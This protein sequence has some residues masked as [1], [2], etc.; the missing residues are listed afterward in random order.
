MKAI[1]GSI[2][3]LAAAVML[4]SGIQIQVPLFQVAWMLGGLLGIAGVFILVQGLSRAE[5]GSNDQD[6]SYDD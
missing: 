1:A 6:A 3:I 5:A 2:V 4:A